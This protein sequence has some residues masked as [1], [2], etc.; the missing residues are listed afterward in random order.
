MA[1][2]ITYQQLYAL[3]EEYTYHKIIYVSFEEKEFVLRSLG[4]EEY[5]QI[6]SIVRDEKDLEDVLAQAALIF[7]EEYD[8]AMSP[9]AGIPHTLSELVLEAS[10]VTDM[11]VLVDM[12]HQSQVVANRFDYQ[13]LTVIKAAMPEES[14]EDMQKWT[15]EKIMFYTALA[16]KILNFTLPEDAQIDL[17]DQREKVQEE[18]KG[19]KVQ[20]EEEEKEFVMNLRKQGI[21]PM[22]YFYDSGTIRHNLIEDPL[23]GGRYWDNE[24]VLNEIRQTIHERR[25]RRHGARR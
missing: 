22:F 3:K 1:K 5:N 14:F 7:P 2:Q 8:M 24:G 6:I 19:P 16:Q 10:D 12:L 23:L 11:N 25:Y 9:H 15:W 17:V 4:R 13:C 18:M 21:D 20:T